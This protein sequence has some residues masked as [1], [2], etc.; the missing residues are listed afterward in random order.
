MSTPGRPGPTSRISRA[1]ILKAARRYYDL[2]ESQTQ[3]A[4]EMGISGGYLAR[5]LKTAKESG[6]VRVFI[7]AD[8]ETE[9]AI[10]MKAAFPHLEHVEVV[11]SSESPEA[12]AEA[13]AT[14]T[15]AWF[16]DL[17]DRDDAREKREIWN[18]TIG[19]AMPHRLMVD[20]IVPRA[21][22]VSVGPTAL[23][24]SPARVE[25]H[26]APIVASLLALRLGALT[27]GAVT[28]DPARRGFLYS[29]S[30]LRPPAG[31]IHALRAWYTALAEDSDF[32][33]MTRFWNEADVV[34]LSGVSTSAIYGDVAGRLDRLGTSREAMEARGAVALIANQ[35]V[36][37]TG[38]AVPLAEGVPAY[39]PAIPV[40]AMR[41][42]V[43]RGRHV[44]FDCWGRKAKLP[45]SIVS[46]GLCTV[47][48]TDT[49]NATRMLGG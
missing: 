25:R 26:T 37:A 10:R 5:L 8:R 40:E 36:D 21:N 13:V 6:W 7:D 4:A 41:Q 34:F 32:V 46:S 29:P 19:G 17:L 24:P 16:N 14:V 22:R 3:I 47:L 30:A 18:V 15:A 12:M 48:V 45:V 28:S 39:E 20:Q 44:V 49:E 42:A 31:D 38:N 11:K 33:E 27:P 35:F 2:G 1:D 9:L 23:T 43:K